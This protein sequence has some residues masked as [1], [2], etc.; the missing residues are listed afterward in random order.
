M[1]LPTLWRFWDQSFVNKASFLSSQSLTSGR[2]W[3]HLC[4]QGCF[5]I[6]DDFRWL[7]ICYIKRTNYWFG[8][9]FQCLLSLDFCELRFF[10]VFPSLELITKPRPALINSWSSSLCFLKAVITEGHTAS[11][12]MHFIKCKDFF[13]FPEKYINVCY[14]CYTLM[15]LK[16]S[17]WGF[18]AVMMKSKR[19][20]W[21]LQL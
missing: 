16:L 8:Y 5:L 6:R 7:Q 18:I 20:V 11:A 19:P 12:L 13:V 21:G 15:T 1:F 9:V 17:S 14:K 10:P 4:V 2:H 3:L